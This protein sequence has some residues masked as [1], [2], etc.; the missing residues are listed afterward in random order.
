MQLSRGYRRLH[1]LFSRPPP[2]L[3]ECVCAGVRCD[4]FAGSLDVCV[5]VQSHAAKN[6]IQRCNMGKNPSMMLVPIC[7]LFPASPPSSG[8]C[9]CA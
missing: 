5:C 2:P 4:V 7:V 6:H 9:V 1:A 8:V 3:D